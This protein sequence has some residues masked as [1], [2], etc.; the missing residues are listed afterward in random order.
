MTP[1]EKPGPEAL[2][3]VR[4]LVERRLTPEEARAALAVP[5]LPEEE[6]ETRAMIRWFRRRYPTPAARLGWLRRAWKRWD[7]ARPEKQPRSSG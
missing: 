3:R 5:L 4:A 6:A 7:A 1:V 2:A